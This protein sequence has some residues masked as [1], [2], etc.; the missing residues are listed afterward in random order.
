MKEE[1]SP[2]GAW[3]KDSEAVACK[4]CSK[5]F[6]IARRKHHCRQEDF[7]ILIIPY[8]LK[9]KII[10]GI[11]VASFVTVAATTRCNF[12]ALQSR[13]ASVTTATPC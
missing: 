1:V 5:E 6:N 8:C 12:R 11:V 7:F 9:G 3:T 4:L 2:A 10:S 13:C